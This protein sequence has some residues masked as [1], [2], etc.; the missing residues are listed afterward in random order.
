MLHV[1]DQYG[2]AMF[3]M[4]MVPPPAPYIRTDVKLSTHK[5]YAPLT[6]RTSWGGP[7]LTVVADELYNH[8]QMPLDTAL[9][10]LLIHK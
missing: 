5:M 2:W 1:E 4:A 10:L 3:I 6:A 8:Q 7:P 9:R